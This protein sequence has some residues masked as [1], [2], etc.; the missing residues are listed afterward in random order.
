[1]NHRSRLTNMVLPTMAALVTVACQVTAS[2]FPTPTPLP[3]FT[4]TATSTPPPTSTP[5]LPPTVTPTITPT[6]RPDISG[7]VLR[8]ADLPAGFQEVSLDEYGM[9]KDAFS[10]GQ[11]QVENVFTFVNPQRFQMVVGYNFLLTRNADRVFF[12]AGLSQPDL[13]LRLI[14]NAMSQ[15][16]I[17]NQKLL[18]GMDDIGEA[19]I[20]MSVVV[21]SREI[22][23][24]TSVLMFRRGTVGEVLISMVIEGQKPNISLHDLGVKLDKRVNESVDQMAMLVA[25]CKTEGLMTIIATPPNWAN[26]GEIFDLFETTTGV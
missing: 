14:T 1:M 4:P 11:F 2:L 15:A 25:A 22:A 18:K 23:M 12:D 17:R 20:A 6:P 9:S 8:L 10:T 16:K 26:Y 19:R 7:A 24:Q 21:D 5:T 13:M 3:S